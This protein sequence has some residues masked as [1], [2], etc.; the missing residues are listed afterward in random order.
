[1]VPDHTRLRLTARL[2]ALLLV[3]G[4]GALP[5]VAGARSE[6]PPRHEPESDPDAARAPPIPRFSLTFSPLHLVGPMLELTGE[7]KLDDRFGLA[8]IA[9]FGTLATG[10]ARA[11]VYELGVSA[12]FYP[13][14]DFRHGLQLGIETLYAGADSSGKGSASDGGSRA[15]T[16]VS[17]GTFLGYKY[18]AA[19]GFTFEAQGGSSTWRPRPPA[20]PPRN[21]PTV[22][23]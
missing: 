6:E 12:R 23:C 11:S 14:G 9:G 8:A 21:R 15:A 4:H 7:G 18:A 10:N 17:V 13:I 16:G 19:V 1:M 5:G 2:F 20:A 22:R 3:V